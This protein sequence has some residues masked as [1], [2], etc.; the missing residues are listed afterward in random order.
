MKLI[1]S[2]IAL[3]MAATS[4]AAHKTYD[5]QTL[6]QSKVAEA[7]GDINGDGINDIAII[8]APIKNEPILAIFWGEKG[9]QYKLFKTYTTLLPKNHEEYI[10]HDY[11]IEITKR[12]TLI[13]SLNQWASAGGWGTTTISYTSRYQ[14]GDFFVIGKDYETMQRNSGD[15]TD[16]SYNYLTGKRITRQFNAFD[17]KKKPK[18]TTKFFPKKPLTSLSTLNLANE[19]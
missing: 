2:L 4:A 11:S 19:F 1:Y 7:K 9:G 10:I 5:L 15:A 17:S 13:F 14:D 8:A 6:Q 3:L 16:D 18:T 12:K